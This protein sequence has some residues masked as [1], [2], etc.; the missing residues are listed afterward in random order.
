MGKGC[1]AAGRPGRERIHVEGKEDKVSGK[2]N[3]STS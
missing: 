1:R 3:A 2:K